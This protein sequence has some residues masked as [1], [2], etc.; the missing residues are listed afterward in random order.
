MSSARTLVS[1]TFPPIPGRKVI[2]VSL[3]ALPNSIDW[4]VIRP[5]AR[6]IRIFSRHSP[7]RNRITVDPITISTLMLTCPT[8][9]LFPNLMSLSVVPL[10]SPSFCMDF[11]CM[12]S[13]SLTA[14]D[15]CLPVGLSPDDM[16][17]MAH[18]VVNRSPGLKNLFV[19][20]SDHAPLASFIAPLSSLRNLQTF[21]LSLNNHF[22][23]LPNLT[24]HTIQPF[25]EL[26]TL[27]VRC[28]A[29]Q[30][31]N[32]LRSIQANN[33]ERLHLSVIAGQHLVPEDAASKLITTLGSQTRWSNSLHAL[34]ITF[35]GALEPMHFTPEL[36]IFGNLT[37]L[38]HHFVKYDMSETTLAE[39]AGAWPQ[40]E[41]LIIVHVGAAGLRPCAVTC[42]AAFATHSPKLRHLDLGIKLDATMLSSYQANDSERDTVPNSLELQSGKLHI[43]I[44]SGS[45]IRDP[46]AVAVYIC[47]LFPSKHLQ[48]GLSTHSHD[49]MWEQAQHALD[50]LFWEH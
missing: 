45:P 41:K 29:P 23:S 17:T 46:K 12:L 19:N 34:L 1:P 42:L 43:V 16:H 14:L 30:M 37:S 40:M 21:E 18:L 35:C 7:H 9:P 6:R 32:L 3:E 24:K 50:N 39:M 33:L 15:V 11:G 48:L 22:P 28:S 49:S 10:S 31:M 2:S 20:V 13:G 4:E 47:Q 8:S 25:P 26:R 27:L 5:F 44:H 38:Q 36:Y